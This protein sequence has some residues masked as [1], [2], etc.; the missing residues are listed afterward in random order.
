[1]TTETPYLTTA[2]AGLDTVLG[3]GLPA[4]ALVFVVGVPGAGK[5]V[6]ASQLL[7]HAARNGTPALI[8]TAFSEGHVK[9]IEHV[10][11]FAFF[12]E[13]VLGGKLTILSLHALLE[14][15]ADA[16]VTIGRTIRET[17]AR[18]VLI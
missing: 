6:L 15:E 16:A 4:R 7:F 13:Q 18:V 10:R 12:D 8:L 11:S 5:T 17:G 3:G 14:R 2:V 1:M 9:L